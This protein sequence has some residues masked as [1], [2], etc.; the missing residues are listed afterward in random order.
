[1]SRPTEL[2]EQPVPVKKTT[3]KYRAA[4]IHYVLWPLF[5]VCILLLPI[6]SFAA[7]YTSVQSKMYEDRTFL[8]ETSIFSPF[9]PI[10]IVVDFK[11][12]LPGSYNLMTDWKTPWGTLEHQ[13]MHT[14]EIHVPAPTYKVYSWL[15]LW[16]NGP[17]K[18]AVTGEEFKKEFYGLWEVILYL[19]GDEVTSQQFEIR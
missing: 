12:L 17:F 14:F 10:Y 6:S 5:F 9:E 1:L 4:G 8:K 2:P 19:N 13:S 15:Q 18:R 16:K 7:E 3:E 11:Q